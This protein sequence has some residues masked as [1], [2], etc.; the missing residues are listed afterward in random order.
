V[1]PLRPLGVG[2]LLDGAFTSI[3]RNPRATLGIAAVL[4]TISGVITTVV[5]LALIHAA[6]PVTLPTAGQHLTQSQVDHLI[7]Q[8]LGVFLPLAGVSVLLSFIV[9]I[10][11]TGL[12]TVVISRCV[13]GPNITAAD[14]WRIARP[15][16]PALL[17]VTLLILCIIGGMW[18]ALGVLL[19]ILAA[20]GAPGGVV[21]LIGVP[22]A[23]AAVVLTVWFSV[24]FR[25]AGPAVVLE[26]ERAVPSLGRSW[27]LVKGS[28]WRVFG[29]SLLAG[30]IVLV[31]T[32][33]LQ[34]PFG[35]L[36]ALAGGGSGSLAGGGTFFA[37]AGGNVA[38]VIISAVG[39]IVAGSVAR[40][41][42]AGVAVLLYVDLRM[43]REGL[44]L[45][46]QTAAAGEVPAG[47]EFASL[48]RPGA[49]AAGSR[50]DH[51]DGFPPPGGAPPAW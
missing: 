2:E 29:I 30:L 32:G 50:Q 20:A 5:T 33:V 3:R 44:D 43:R 28:F 14:A 38:G 35:L 24:M 51:T 25:M 23:L 48:W 15:R 6:G 18:L 26:R 13:L 31:T 12:L 8:L 22:G 27:R 11:L 21:A 42:S 36:A 37:G 47:D 4:L 10:I 46:L 9:D 41:I 19:V 16:L 39:G 49:Q 34:I 40:P 17:G 1:I 45:V 7:G